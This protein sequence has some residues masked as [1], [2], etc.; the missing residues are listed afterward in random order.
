MAIK[1]LIQSFLAITITTTV[2]PSPSPVMEGGIR[3]EEVEEDPVRIE[4]R[5][6][7]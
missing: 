7:L 4:T 3:K 5:T 2:L 1:V 6:L